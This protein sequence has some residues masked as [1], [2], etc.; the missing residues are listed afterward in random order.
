MLI[1]PPFAVGAAT[2][3]G[4]DRLGTFLRNPAVKKK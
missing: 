1:E 2:S 3:K 4:T